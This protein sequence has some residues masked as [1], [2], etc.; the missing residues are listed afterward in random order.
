M[1]STKFFKYLKAYIFISF[2]IMLFIFSCSLMA[3]F[4]FWNFVF[5]LQE[6]LFIIRFSLVFGFI[7]TLFYIFVEESV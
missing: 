2:T 5:P 4:I 6:I 3:S 1:K 7:I